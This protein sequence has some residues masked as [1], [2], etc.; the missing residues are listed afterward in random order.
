MV[1]MNY[2]IIIG[3]QINS[4]S[5][6][7][8]RPEAYGAAGDGIANDTAKVQAA[9]DAATAAG[10]GTVK[11]D[12]TYGYTKTAE[13]PSPVGPYPVSYGLWLNSSNVIIDGGGNGVLKLLSMPTFTNPFIGFLIGNGGFSG[14]FPS[15]GWDWLE[16]NGTWTSHVTFKDISF[17]HSVLTDANLLTLT[18]G[19]FNSVLAMIFCEDSLISGVTIDRAWGSTGGITL[20]GSSRRCT[21]DHCTITLTQ[22]LGF[23]FDGPSDCSFSDLI[24]AGFLV[25]TAELGIMLACNTDY[26]HDSTRC[27]INHCT[28]SGV[29]TGIGTTGFD[30][31]ISNNTIHLKDDS[32]VHIG[33]DKRIGDTSLMADDAGRLT[34]TGNTVDHASLPR[35]GWAFHTSGK[36][37]TIF[38]GLPRIISHCTITGNTI[39]NTDYG[40][41]IDKQSQYNTFQYNTLNN[42][43]ISVDISSGTAIEN[44]VS[45]N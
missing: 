3:S 38:D 30:H 19:S 43:A 11:L 15:G 24:V 10:G 39:T 40:Y 27:I 28:L 37:A 17:N 22:K 44:I 5:Q 4:P 32:T 18:T 26:R 13:A 23:H 31:T 20:H 45:P 41:V 6:G 16:A 35:K 12:R 42:A 7:I 8:Y 29:H 9:L 34:V 21:V 36:N 1:I 25:T 14:S 33:V 2:P